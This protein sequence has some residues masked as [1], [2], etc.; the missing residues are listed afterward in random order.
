MQAPVAL[1]QK[2]RATT[3]GGSF[4]YISLGMPQMPALDQPFAFLFFLSHDHA[5]LYRCYTDG[6]EFK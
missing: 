2:N 1:C 6:T 3:I 4:R 5:G